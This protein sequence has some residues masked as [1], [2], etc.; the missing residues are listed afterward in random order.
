M[1]IFVHKLIPLQIII[2]IFITNLKTDNSC[3]VKRSCYA[4]VWPKIIPSLS[5]LENFLLGAG[6]LNITYHAVWSLHTH[7]PHNVTCLRQNIFMIIYLT[8]SKFIYCLRCICIAYIWMILALDGLQ[9]LSYMLYLCCY[10]INTLLH[11]IS[12]RSLKNTFHN[13]IPAD[14]LLGLLR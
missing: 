11:I 8:F 2:K 9:I 4:F 7:H 14:L 10:C 1:F 12:I 5:S 13:S 6:L 3:I